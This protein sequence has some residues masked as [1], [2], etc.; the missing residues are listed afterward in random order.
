MRTPND[1]PTRS[2]ALCKRTLSITPLTVHH[3]IPRTRHR[4][5]RTRRTFTK[6]EVKTRTVLLC[7]P[8]HDQVHA[9]ISEKELERSY[10]T[11]E[12]LAAHPDV[13]A[14]AVWMA[15]KPDGFK[16]RVRKSA[17]R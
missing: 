11:I 2:C 16:A 10:N 9:L 12:T 15:G 7:R 1:H 8:C 14:F 6:E 4:N 3:L 13:A 17:E 5:K